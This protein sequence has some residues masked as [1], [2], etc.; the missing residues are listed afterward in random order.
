MT[1]VQPSTL[2]NRAPRYLAA[3]SSDM[4]VSSTIKASPRSIYRVRT[5]ST[6][7]IKSQTPK[8]LQRRHCSIL[9]SVE[10]HPILTHLHSTIF[11]AVLRGH[12]ITVVPKPLLSTLIGSTRVSPFIAPPSARNASP[13]IFRNHRVVKVHDPDLCHTDGSRHIY[14]GIPENLS[15][16]FR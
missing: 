9:I 6:G 16:S 5:F 8:T 3:D 4:A 10:N 15:H 11:R 7:M 2:T 14:P 12:L 1:R 13:D